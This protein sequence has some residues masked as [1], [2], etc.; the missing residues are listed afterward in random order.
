MWEENWPN[1]VMKMKDMPYYH[2]KSS[3]TRSRTKDDFSDAI[4]GTPE[5]LKTKFA[6]YIKK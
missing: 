2:Y 4:P 3:G 6:R 1:L 5:I